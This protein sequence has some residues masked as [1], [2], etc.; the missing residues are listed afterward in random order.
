MRTLSLW[1]DPSP[2]PLGENGEKSV[3][4]D[5]AFRVDGTLLVVASGRHLVV[6]NTADGKKLRSRIGQSYSALKSTLDLSIYLPPT[7]PT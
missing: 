3:V 2:S 7:L 4:W 1:S 6:Y 5:A